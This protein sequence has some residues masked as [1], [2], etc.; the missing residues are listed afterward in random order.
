M[1]CEQNGLET[2]NFIAVNQIF[3]LHFCFRKYNQKHIRKIVNNNILAQKQPSYDLLPKQVLLLFARA[4][5][6]RWFQEYG[7][8]T[9]PI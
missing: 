5:L 8:L 1:H 2:L 4:L 6:I 9:Y 7:S 3:V